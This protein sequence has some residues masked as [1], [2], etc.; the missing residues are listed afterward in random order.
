MYLYEKLSIAIVDDELRKDTPCGYA[1]HELIKKMNEEKVDPADQRWYM[2]LRMCDSV[3]QSGFML[4][5]ERLI[6]WICKLKSVE[7]A[8][9]FPRSLDKLYP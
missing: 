9:A 1:M 8:S 6:R 2:D 5:L 7:E 4:G 3:C